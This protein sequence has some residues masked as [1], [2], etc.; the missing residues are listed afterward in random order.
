MQQK[1]SSKKGSLDPTSQRKK[2][3]SVEF[4]TFFQGQASKISS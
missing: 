3:K 4:L 1:I 2:S